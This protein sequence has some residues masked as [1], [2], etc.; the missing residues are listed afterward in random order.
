MAWVA[1]LVLAQACGS[2]DLAGPI[3]SGPNMNVSRAFFEFAPA[4]GVGMGTECAC[5][6]PTGS[7]LEALTFSRA[8]VAE[9]P[10][11]DGQKLTQCASGQPRV[12][13]GAV[14]Q[15]ILGLWQEDART[16]LALQARDWS[17]LVWTKT[18][19]TCARTANGMR[20][21]DANGASTCTSSAIN[22][23]ALQAITLTIQAFAASYRIKRRTGTGTVGVTVDGT[24]FTDVASS[25]SSVEWRWVVPAEIPGCTSSTAPTGSKCIVV[26]GLST[27]A[28]NPTI[29]IRLGTSGDA[30][31]VDFAQ[32]EA[33]TAGTATSPIETTAGSATRIVELPDVA[34][35]PTLALGF[36]AA[37]TTVSQVTSLKRLN[38]AP[39]S[40]TPGVATGSVSYVD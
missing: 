18:S 22:G 3:Y 13:S 36:C 6:T 15:T 25:L 20:N 12:S 9:C 30:V 5:T 21:A 37:A 7:R 27:T 23:T 16:N 31:D 32:L 4:N 17:Q 28:A 26:P 19:M 40:G 34:I 38:G 24:T 10:S 29:G 11:A 2:P 8:S 14:D 1:L 33:S 35:S 39:G